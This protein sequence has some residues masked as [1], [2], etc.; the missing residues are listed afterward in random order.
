MDSKIQRMP[1]A[2]RE[3]LIQFRVGQ[4]AAIGAPDGPERGLEKMYPNLDRRAQAVVKVEDDGF[5]HRLRVRSKQRKI[6]QTAGSRNPR[7]VMS[8]VMVNVESDG[9]IPADNLGVTTSPDAR[10]PG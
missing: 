8:Y 10:K 9:P 3:S 7:A 4:G 6:A 1:P 2:V 5:D